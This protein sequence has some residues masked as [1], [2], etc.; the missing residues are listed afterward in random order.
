M[1]AP[2]LGNVKLQF[3]V[4]H[5]ASRDVQVTFGDIAKLGAMS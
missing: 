4:N 2:K 1:K 5:Q 3:W